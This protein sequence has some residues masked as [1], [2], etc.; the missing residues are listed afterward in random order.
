MPTTRDTN[1]PFAEACLD[2]EWRTDPYAAY[3]RAA[4]NACDSDGSDDYEV[5][6]SGAVVPP[7]MGV[8]YARAMD[9]VR[10]APESLTAP[11]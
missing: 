9:P 4:E 8:G 11:V 2:D 10:T 5:V 1:W 6:E 7:R 3:T